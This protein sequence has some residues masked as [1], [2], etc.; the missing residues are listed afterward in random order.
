MHIYICIYYAREI[1][2]IAKKKK[3]VERFEGLRFFASSFLFFYLLRTNKIMHS[4]ERNK[5]GGDI[6]YIKSYT[7]FTYCLLIFS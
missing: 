4:E 5:G 6:L 2:F 1:C 3:E 7:Q